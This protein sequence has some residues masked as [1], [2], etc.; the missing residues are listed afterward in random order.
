MHDG[1]V[2][3]EQI[4]DGIWVLRGLSRASTRSGNIVGLGTD[5]EL[6]GLVWLR[7]AY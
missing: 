6:G 4:A 3:I 2:R 1:R 5:D 7:E